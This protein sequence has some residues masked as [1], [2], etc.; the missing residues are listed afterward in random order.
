MKNCCDTESEIHLVL[1]Q[2]RMMPLGPWLTSPAT[3]LVNHPT[4]YIMSIIN[5]AP[6]SIDNDDGHNKVLVERQ[7]KNGKKYDTPKYYTLLPIGSTVAVQ[8]ED[9]DRWTHGTIVGKGDYN[10]IN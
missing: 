10:H 6:M 5:R 2:V 4:K 3:L 1:L 9:G 8:R 7:N